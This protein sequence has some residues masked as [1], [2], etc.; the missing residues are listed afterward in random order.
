[1]SVA[2]LAPGA[3]GAARRAVAVVMAAARVDG[4][5]AL[6]GVAVAV[7]EGRHGEGMDRVG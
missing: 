2:S 4:D 1:M 6:A 3:V 7:A 5:V